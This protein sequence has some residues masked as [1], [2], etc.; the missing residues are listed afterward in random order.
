MKLQ[1][2]RQRKQVTMSKVIR[3]AEDSRRL[4]QA[5]VRHL[6]DDTSRSQ[7]TRWLKDGSITSADGQKLKA[8]SP[9][10]AG[11]EVLLNEPPAVPDDLIPEEMPL[12]IIYEDEDILVINKPQGLVV[13]PGAGNHSGTLVN[14]LLAYNARQLSAGSDPKR[15]GIVHRID[16]DTSGLLVV[17]K[18][19]RAHRSLSDDLR[20]HRIARHYT[21][22]VYGQMREEQGLIDAPL[23]RDPANRKRMAVNHAG[24]SARTHYKVAA[25]LKHGSLLNISL[26]T[27]RTH[28][29]R[30]HLK[31]I[32]HP[33]I[34][35]PVY[36]PGRMNFG[37]H[38]Q[39]LHAQEL[40]LN[41]PVSG[42]TMTFR[43]PLPEW[44]CR[45]LLELGAE[46]EAC[47]QWSS[48]AGMVWPE[49]PHLPEET[50]IE[51]LYLEDNDE[52]EEAAY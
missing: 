36:A 22:V 45:L 11:D 23:A 38:G 14:G 16:K 2:P 40:I 15:P 43:A 42:E 32:S 31:A 21:A 52:G 12:D 20:Y 7:I 9:V 30:A 10:K 6:G 44:F 25:R 47:R 27:G 33:I 3:F 29:I 5:L 4:D 24:R 1:Q 34:G 39:A 48:G 13:H 49:T 51:E 41:H 37:L 28:Q 18:T 17:A 26:E 46:A 8:G 35:D 19:D 50:D